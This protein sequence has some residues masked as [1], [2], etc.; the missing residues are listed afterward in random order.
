M[1]KLIPILILIACLCGTV[2]AEDFT[3]LHIV[4]TQN[5]LESDK[6]QTNLPPI[7]CTFWRKAETAENLVWVMQGW[8]SNSWM[9]ASNTNI[10]ICEM[11]FTVEQSMADLKST[12][13]AVERTRIKDKVK[14]DPQIEAAING[15]PAGNRENWGLVPRP[16]PELPQ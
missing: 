13:T 9:L 6:V 2:Q 12:L 3:Y 5:R 8:N 11:L 15:D 14:N 1:K 10:V 16:Q 7:L 4:M